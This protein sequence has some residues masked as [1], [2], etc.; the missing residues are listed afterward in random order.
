[1]MKTGIRVGGEV[2]LLHGFWSASSFCLSVMLFGVALPCVLDGAMAKSDLHPS[3]AAFLQSIAVEVSDSTKVWWSQIL[4]Q[5]RIQS[6]YT[7]LKTHLKVFFSFPPAPSICSGTAVI[8]DFLPLLC[9]WKC[10][11]VFQFHAIDYQIINMVTFHLLCALDTIVHLS[12]YQE[13][14]EVLPVQR[15][16]GNITL[17][18]CNNL[19]EN[20][21]FVIN[22]S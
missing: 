2:C 9:T 21:P 18:D 19:M 20:M 5:R 3:H 12:V 15:Q 16:C 7:K 10:S 4:Q 17:T 8:S 14:L 1:M 11:Y 6:W 13:H 22:S